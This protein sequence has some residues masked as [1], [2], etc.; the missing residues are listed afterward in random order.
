MSGYDVIQASTGEEAIEVYQSRGDDISLVIMDVVMPGM[1]GARALEELW[2]INPELRCVVSSGFG[3]EAI[4]ENHN[5]HNLRF[6]PKPFSTANVT[7]AI[8]D[9]LHA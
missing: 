6:V 1:G 3:A 9:L 2:K 5:G 7:N 8:Q 4:T